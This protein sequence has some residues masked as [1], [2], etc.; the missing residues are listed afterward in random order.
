MSDSFSIHEVGGA[1]LALHYPDRGLIPDV[2]WHKA[3]LA[4]SKK[5]SG[6]R[7]VFEKSERFIA[8][9][10]SNGDGLR[11]FV[12][13]DKFA[14]FIPWTE[15]TV[16]AERSTPGTMVRLQTAA[17]P[18]VELHFHLDDNAADALFSGVMLPLPK[19]E[20]PGR[21]SWPKPWAVGALIG[22]MLGAA[23][24]LA[25]VNLS[26][27]NRTIAAVVASVVIWSLWNAFRSLLEEDH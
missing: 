20:P 1:E 10:S 8:V 11:I 26:W 12:A 24:L 18:S 4:A 19:R 21:L 2:N 5:K 25:V 16:S 9:L 22:V 23:G 6:W 15:L 14:T 3:I 7:R 13:L 17:E 27:I